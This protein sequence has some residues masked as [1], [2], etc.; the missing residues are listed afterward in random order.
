MTMA[1]DYFFLSTIAFFAGF[2]DTVAGGGGLITVPALLSTGLDPIVALGTN[3]LQSAIS[4]MAA[5]YRFAVRKEVSFKQIGW[6]LCFT[7][8]GASLGTILLQITPSKPLEIIVPILLFLVLI[9][10]FLP[11]SCFKQRQ[12]AVPRIK[13][14]MISGLLIGF[15]NGFFGPGTGSIWTVAISSALIIPLYQATMLTKPLNLMGNLSALLWFLLGGQIHYKIAF[16]MGI[17]SLLG[18]LLGSRFV[19]ARNNRII[20]ILFRIILTA[21]VLSSVYGVFKIDF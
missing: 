16:F 18:G 20:Q 21:S 3:K 6:G 15:Y 14:F 2:V 17:G 13:F 7:L 11:K 1:H 19:Q 10:T 8:I 5:S 9:Y 12:A 4:E